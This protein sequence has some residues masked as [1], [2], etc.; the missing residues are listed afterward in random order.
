M[1]HEASFTELHEPVAG[2]WLIRILAIFRSERTAL[3]SGESFTRAYAENLSHRLPLL[4]CVALFDTAVL[5]ASFRGVAP[6][7]LVIWLPLPFVV[8]GCLRAVYWLPRNV[9]RR[10]LEV[11]SRDIAWLSVVGT[12]I[13]LVPMCW[14][15]LLYQFGDQ[16]QQSLVHYVTAVTCFTGILSLGQAPRTAIRMATTVML[17]SSIFFLLHDH[18][19]KFGIVAVQIVVTLLLLLITAGYHDDFVGLE[20]SRQELSRRE[21]QSARLAEANRL[22]AMRDPLTGANN[23][24]AILAMFSQTLA[25]S[26]A[27]PPWLA[28]VDLDGFK[29]INDTYGH[30]AGD[31]VLCAVKMRIEAVPEIA[32]FGRLGG[33]EF[34]ILMS[35]ALA[36]SAVSSALEGLSRAICQPICVDDLR[37]LVRASIGLHQCQGT[38]LGECLERADTALYKAKEDRSG[39]VAIFTESDERAM[40][41]RRD[42]IRVFTS[43]DLGQ[44]LSLV[45]QPIIDT[46]LGRPV[47][48]EAL[49][50]WSPDGTIWLPPAAFIS[51]A[52]TTGRIGE[53]TEHVLCKALNECRVWQWGCS[54]AIN[55]SARDILRD[56][57]A[58]WI[59][60]IVAA[61]G[62][63]PRSIILEITE[64]A[65]VSDYRRAADT[66][67]KL[68]QAGFRIA[69][70]DFGTGQSSLSHVHNLPI[71]HLKIDQ[72]FAR[73]LVPSEGSRAVVSTILA[74]ARQLQLD[75]TIEGIETLAQ[76]AIARSLGVRMMQG[77]HFSRPIKA[78]EVIQGL[79]ANRSA[80]V[81]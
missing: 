74:L 51:L 69:L 66:L 41:E 27:S 44:Q 71:D 79:D 13:S 16:S 64:T 37:L 12:T 81:A 60:A 17:P 28:L 1:A 20:L 52:E 26:S 40:R 72:S 36:L 61:A 53:L 10:S 34:A 39:A 11:L 31:A 70:D 24:R 62:A 9:K 63:P 29:H 56:D 55:L 57:A 54:L 32:A 8:I 67:A 14:S 47:T 35:G 80:N 50:R 68:R 59:G 77:Y 15:L 58:N 3:Q 4:Y 78:A 76:Q 21:K 7:F 45:Y 23:R 25:D 49:V 38:Q 73:D 33:D 46:D 48:F 18:P 75:C 22:N 43:A 2:T 30:A 19:N 42:A 6:A 5:M 65:L